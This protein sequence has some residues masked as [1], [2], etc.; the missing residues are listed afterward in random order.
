MTRVLGYS[1]ASG[2]GRILATQ[3]AGLRRIVGV[4]IAFT[5]HLAATLLTM[6][7]EGLGAA[8]LPLTL[9]DDDLRSGRLIRAGASTFDIPVDIRL[10]RSPDCRSHAADQLW[11]HLNGLAKAD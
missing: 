9:T 1:P 8:W 6:A 3:H 11:D 2:L 5:S 10:F 7:R 4:E